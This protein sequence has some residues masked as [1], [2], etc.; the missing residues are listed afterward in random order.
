VLITFTTYAPHALEV[1]A[2]IRAGLDLAERAPGLCER[3]THA[4]HP[5]RPARTT[6]DDRVHGRPR[7]LKVQTRLHIDIQSMRVRAPVS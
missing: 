7:R 4:A 5:P 3:M 6:Y 1:A 2:L